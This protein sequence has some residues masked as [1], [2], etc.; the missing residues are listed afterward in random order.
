MDRKY[1]DIWLGFDGRAYMVVRVR[2]L[3]NSNLFEDVTVLIDPGSTSCGLDQELIKRLNG[4]SYLKSPLILGGILEI[5]MQ[6]WKGLIIEF[7]AK[8]TLTGK[9]IEIV[10]QSVIGGIVPKNLK[11][12]L[13]YHGLL[14]IN[15]IEDNNCKI[16]FD[17]TTYPSSVS[18]SGILA[19]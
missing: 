1:G 8:D 17:Y 16:I 12:K 19:K 14:G 10:D 4:I 3:E 6:W 7:L 5:E 18:I 13:A 2:N 15:I 9:Y 11:T